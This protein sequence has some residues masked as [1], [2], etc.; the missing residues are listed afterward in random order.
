VKLNHP[1]VLR[2]LGWAPADNKREAEIHTEF[3][4]NG[5][6]KEVLEKSHS[7]AKPTFWNPTG[8]AIIICGVVLGMRYVHQCQILHLDLKPSNILIGDKGH[9]LVG[10]FGSSC[11]IY[12]ATPSEEMTTPYYAAPEMHQEHIPRTTKCDVF[13]FGLVLYEI[14]VGKPVFHSSQGLLVVRRRVFSGDFAEIPREVGPVMA[15]LILSCWQKVPKDRPS[16]QD[17]FATFESLHFEILPGADGGQ[18][19]D[20]CGAILDWEQRARI[21]M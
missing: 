11:L 4:T 13:S 6:L 19:G 14:L 12:D 10:D 3:A 2:I 18:I 5:S 17:I 8:I 15:K 16:F 7:G 21:R 20:F 9:P 1:C